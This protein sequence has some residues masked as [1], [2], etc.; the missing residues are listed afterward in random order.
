[1]GDAALHLA[2]RLQ[3]LPDGPMLLTPQEMEREM[4]EGRLA[5]NRL[6]GNVSETKSPAKLPRGIIDLP[7]LSVDIRNGLSEKSSH[8]RRASARRTLVC[9]LRT[10][11]GM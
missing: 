3:W 5:F 2:Q 10:L 11:R 9:H 1:M 7:Q 4:Q 8:T 6:V